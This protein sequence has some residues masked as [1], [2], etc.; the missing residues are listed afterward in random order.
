[1]NRN[2]LKIWTWITADFKRDVD[3]YKIE[4]KKYA[5][6]GI[7]ALLINTHTNCDLL[8][9]L[10]P[11][12]IDLGL[13]VH[14]WI[15]TMN[16]A[17]DSIAFKNPSWYAVNRLG[18]SCFDK[19]PYVEYYQWLCPTQNDSRNHILGLI[20]SLS[21]VKD[22]S[23]IH[24]D[25]IR[26]SDIYLPIGLQPKYNVIQ[27]KE[28]PVYDYCYCDTCVREFEIIYNKNPKTMKLP[29]LDIEWK[30]FRLNKIKAIVDDAYDLVHKN[31]KKLS[32]AVFPYPEM[33]GQ[34]VRQR[35]DKWNIDFI[36]PMLYHDF[37]DEDIDWITS[38]TKQSL[39]DIKNKGQELH[40]GIFVGKLSSNELSQILD[41]LGK[42]GAEGLSIFSGKGIKEEHFDILRSYK[43]L[44]QK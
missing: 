22:V 36:L 33:A 11:L 16:R 27:K 21:L 41:N 24:L 43:G 9:R 4:F 20:E 7:D 31:N 1:M 34:M 10:A 42:T 37:Y 8:K 32:A 6:N 2:K 13:E 23:S 25:Y 28:M 15:W 38:C 17:N 3:S 29:D 40:P 19:R 44:I 18:E 14:S 30:N 39:L 12:A 26:Y 35:W 5:E